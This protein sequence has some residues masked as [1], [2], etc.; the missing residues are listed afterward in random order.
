[1]Q[2]IIQQNTI[3]SRKLHEQYRL[4]DS[5]LTKTGKWD[6]VQEYVNIY[7]YTKKNSDISRDHKN[8]KNRK[9]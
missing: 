1:M 5:F 6:S 2:K 4:E 8:V 9:W 3:K 7:I